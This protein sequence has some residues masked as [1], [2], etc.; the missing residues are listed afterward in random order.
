MCINW[1]TECEVAM[2][3]RTNIVLDDDLVAQAM[4]RARVTTK[5]AAVED[6]KSV[7]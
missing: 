2:N 5:K 7:V 4:V 6:R 3:T 1:Q